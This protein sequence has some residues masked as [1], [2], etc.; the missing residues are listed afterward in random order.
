LRY[1][2]GAP[3]HY[4]LHHLRNRSW[5]QRYRIDACRGT[6]VLRLPTH[7]CNSQQ[8]VLALSD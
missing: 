8:P 4:R 6:P 3:G 1:R 7:Q 5:Y 2:S